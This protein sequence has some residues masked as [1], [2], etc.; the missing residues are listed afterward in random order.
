MKKISDTVKEKP[1]VGWV[2]YLVTIVI[3]FLLGL[4]GKDYEGA[5]E[6]LRLLVLS[7]F[8]VAVYLLFIPIQNVRMKVASIVKLNILRFVLLMGLSY[9]F[10]L[11]FGIIGIGYAW[12]ITY[13]VLSFVIVFITKR[14]G[15]I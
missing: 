14:M 11:K 2:L 5:Y 8:F 9:V 7:S 6:L 12:M 4:L 1:W 13:I 3:V 10:I 15:W